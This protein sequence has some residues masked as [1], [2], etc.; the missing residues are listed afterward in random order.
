LGAAFVV[1]VP[2]LLS[3]TRWLVPVLF[4]VAIL[5]VLVFEPR[6]LAGRWLTARLY[7]RLWPFR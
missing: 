1:L 2:A 6:G 3:E 7:F 4:G 5:V